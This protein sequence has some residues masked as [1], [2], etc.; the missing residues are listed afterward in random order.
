[1]GHSTLNTWVRNQAARRSGAVV[2]VDARAFEGDMGEAEPDA[3]DNGGTEADDE[4]PQFVM[5]FRSL[6]EFAQYRRRQ[7]DP[8]D[9]RPSWHLVDGT[10]K[11]F[12]GFADER[13]ACKQEYVELDEAKIRCDKSVE[14]A[15]LVFT[16]RITLV[17]GGEATIDCFFDHE[18]ARAD[19]K[20]KK[21]MSRFH[22]L[23][24]RQARLELEIEERKAM[25]QEPTAKQARQLSRWTDADLPMAPI[26]IENPRNRL[27]VIACLHEADPYLA[28]TLREGT[29][30][31]PATVH[32][33]YVWGPDADYLTNI[34]PDGSRWLIRISGGETHPQ[35]FMSAVTSDEYMPK[36][37]W[38]GFT[39]FVRSEAF[40]RIANET[41]WEAVMAGDA[42]ARE[43]LRLE[44]ATAIGALTDDDLEGS[45]PRA[46]DGTD[47]A[48]LDAEEAG[49]G[50]DGSAGK[51]REDEAREGEADDVVME[52]ADAAGGAVDEDGSAA[53]ASGAQDGDAR[54]APPPQ[55]PDQQRPTPKERQLRW[56]RDFNIDQLLKVMKI[57][58]G[59]DDV[60]LGSKK[61]AYRQ[62][63]DKL[64]ADMKQAKVDA[65]AGLPNLHLRFGDPPKR[66]D[67]LPARHRPG[68]DEH[69]PRHQDVPW[70]SEET[71]ARLEATT[72]G[73]PDPDQNETDLRLSRLPFRPR[74][75][76]T[77]PA[78]P[79]SNIV[80]DAINIAT[81]L[82]AR[83]SLEPLLIPPKVSPKYDDKGEMADTTTTKKKKKKKGKAGE[84]VEQIQVNGIK[85]L[86]WIALQ[87]AAKLE[88]EEGAEGGGG[89]S[90][91]KPGLKHRGRLS[92]IQKPFD[93][94]FNT[95]AVRASAVEESGLIDD[96][97]DGATDGSGSDDSFLYIGSPWRDLMEVR[98]LHH[99]LEWLVL[100]DVLNG[101]LECA[102][103][104]S[105]LH[106]FARRFYTT[107]ASDAFRQTFGQLAR[108]I[109][110]LQE[111]QSAAPS[112]R[113][114]DNI[115]DATWTELWRTTTGTSTK[116]S[117]D[118]LERI[119]TDYGDLSAHDV[120]ACAKE[121][122]PLFAIEVIRDVNSRLQ[123]N[124]AP[125]V[126]IEFYEQTAKTVAINFAT[127]SRKRVPT[128]ITNVAAHLGEDII[129]KLPALVDGLAAR[130][131]VDVGVS[132]FSAE[133][134]DAHVKTLAQDLA[135]ES[136]QAIRAR[137]ILR[138]RLETLVSTLPLE[139]DAKSSWA[140]SAIEILGKA[141]SPVDK[142]FQPPRKGQPLVASDAAIDLASLIVTEL[143]RLSSLVTKHLTLI[144][145]AAKANP[146]ATLASLAGGRA[147]GGLAILDLTLVQVAWEQQLGQTPKIRYRGTS[148]VLPP[149]MLAYQLIKH[150]TIVT[151][152]LEN[153][154]SL[155]ARCNQAIRGLEVKKPTQPPR[156]APASAAPSA[157]KNQR[158]SRKGAPSAM[159]IL[160]ARARDYPGRL[161]LEHAHSLRLFQ[162]DTDL[163]GDCKIPHLVLDTQR[164]RALK[165]FCKTALAI[166]PAAKRESRIWDKC[167]LAAIPFLYAAPAPSK[168]GL[169]VHG[170]TTV[171]R[172]A[173]SFLMLNP[174]EIKTATPGQVGRNPQAVL[175]SAWRAGGGTQLLSNWAEAAA[176]RAF[177][178]AFAT[179]PIQPCNYARDAIWSPCAT[180]VDDI[181]PMRL[182]GTKVV[183]ADDGADDGV[184]GE[185]EIDTPQ[186]RGRSDA[187]STPSATSHNSSALD[188]FFPS[189]FSLTVPTNA[190]TDTNGDEKS[191]SWPE[192][193]FEI[194]ANT[195]F[196]PIDVGERNTVSAAIVS[197]DFEEIFHVE[198]GN[199]Q[200]KAAN[201]QQAETLARIS[202]ES[203]LTAEPTLT[204]S[205]LDALADRNPTT[206]ALNWE[207]RQTFNDRL[208]RLTHAVAA[209][210]DLISRDAASPDVQKRNI[211]VFI[212]PNLG[213]RSSSASGADRREQVSGSLITALR[214][215]R[216]TDDDLR[217]AVLEA[218]EFRTSITCP[219][220]RFE[221]IDQ[222]KKERIAY[223]ADLTTGFDVF[224]VLQ[225]G[226]C[227]RVFNRD[228]LGAVNIGIIGIVSAA[229]R[230]LKVQVFSDWVEVLS[231]LINFALFEV[232]H[233]QRIL[234]ELDK[235]IQDLEEQE[236]TMMQET[237]QLRKTI[238]ADKE[239][240]A[241]NKAKM[242]AGRG[243]MEQD[244]LHVQ[245]VYN[246][247]KKYHDE[248][249]ARKEDIQRTNGR[250]R[251][252][253]RELD[254]LKLVVSDLQ[255]QIVSSPDK[256]QG[257]IQDLHDQLRRQT[258]MFKET[259]VKERQTTSKISALNQ[260]SQELT[261]C[262]R[263]LEDWQ[264]DVDRLRELES[265]LQQHQDDLQQ[266]EAEHFST[267]LFVKKADLV[268]T[269]DENIKEYRGINTDSGRTILRR[270]CGNC[271]SSIAGVPEADDSMYYLKGGLFDPHTLPSKVQA[272]L[273]TRNF[274]SRQKVHDGAHPVQGMS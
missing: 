132:A 216:G 3:G 266:L 145:P 142:N 182:K 50:A 193:M 154:N 101:L 225:C 129:A 209:L 271:G 31:A 138:L 52:E 147:G 73:T 220:C 103:N 133:S 134:F 180:L 264:N 25:G 144:N 121:E 153:V 2:E 176:C 252:L 6:E 223:A 227:K 112:A 24:T 124:L 76:I 245:E 274:E 201:K 175:E 233:E 91:K 97:R 171:T 117:R 26:E 23:A 123:I 65:K 257:R 246:E 88:G 184:F 57:S 84:A 7:G 63:V 272:E 32:D 221:R 263:L 125:G 161:L 248:A 160:H 236:Q 46:D 70:L 22:K 108:L 75:Q 224:R 93:S 146:T 58:R 168:S 113:N 54:N 247:A 219:S 196:V 53:E 189:R 222:H 260:Y 128:V 72:D 235:G 143:G 94:A 28:R 55:A 45:A 207:Q 109:V 140:V 152:T 77:R 243:K 199:H 83:L 191:E 13:S 8:L 47:V 238:E 110:K 229:F 239:T 37:P 27:R 173:V 14:V 44:M 78:P 218:S 190:S 186:E 265:R 273:F 141:L 136:K 179:S 19:L 51:A 268:I 96:G 20:L 17:F 74:I 188:A 172:H 81:E 198:I 12:G 200:F 183:L 85:E 156:G 67:W 10:G 149:T 80:V 9:A 262:V 107:N 226:H 4:E 106:S 234:E 99:Q 29:A 267:N 130:I 61:E 131:G 197:A 164:M 135:V 79:S 95:F 270:F 16:Q 194:A 126:T 21:S 127:R 36:I 122:L 89:S 119:E 187:K 5:V 102:T 204:L 253:N 259:E 212:G 92:T 165:V 137:N 104:L 148:L 185:R 30:S 249:Q 86:R 41:D 59:D 210:V 42:D 202:R 116:P 158:P 120:Q 174:S 40:M 170:Q 178:D 49:D 169:L 18:D 231:A 203:A 228:W 100:V 66:P 211:V 206:L 256:L 254:K 255:T 68:K 48:M 87:E 162:V 232:E 181:L 38:I 167:P 205:L 242:D 214:A 213:Q 64:K 39:T 115:S 240:R 11:F 157:D 192:E 105:P 230:N 217:V 261:S 62:L 195:I 155:V 159:T 269:G 258:E 1:M 82:N 250:M 150:D 241:E 43:E 208:R 71:W 251:E 163:T 56:F 15:L 114:V 60:P 151:T 34:R 90:S 177:L 69:P 118:D 98:L 237:E 244:L 111:G 139:F 215:L 166:R 33:T 35:L